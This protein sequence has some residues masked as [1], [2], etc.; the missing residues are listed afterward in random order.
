MSLD[1]SA[2]DRRPSATRKGGV[3]TTERDGAGTGF[4]DMK[5]P[6]GNLLDPIEYES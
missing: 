1:G 4:T 2:K 5:D 3:R 6:E